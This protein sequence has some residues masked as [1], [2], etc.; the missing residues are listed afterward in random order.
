MSGESAA[1]QTAEAAEAPAK[2]DEPKE[3][4]QSTEKP[5]DEEKP[6]DPFD[7]ATKNLVG[8]N[9]ATRAAHHQGQRYLIKGAG[10]VLT[11]S[12]VDYL[13]LGNLTYV[14]LTNATK[15]KPG[16]VR[17]E[18]LEQIRASYVKV[19]TYDAI[20]DMLQSRRL[21]LLH[22]P[23]ETGRTTTALHLLDGVTGGRVDRLDPEAEVHSLT[24]DDLEAGRG[25]L[26]KLP[27]SSATALTETHLDRL[28]AS[29]VNKSCWC[30]LIVGSDF[31]SA[32]GVAGYVA[33]YGQL[34]IE[35]VF[36][37]HLARETREADVGIREELHR[38][39][40]SGKVREALG[41]VPSPAEMARL[42]PLLVKHDIDDVVTIL[43][44]YVDDSVAEWFHDVPEPPLGTADERALRFIGYRIALAVLNK[45]PQHHVA[46]AG[47]KLGRRLICTSDPL[48]EPGRPVF[49]SEHHLWL[50]TSRGQLVP[51]D[52]LFGDTTMRIHLAAFHDDRMPVAVLAQVWTRHHNTRA[53]LLQWLNELADSTEPDVWVRAAQAAGMLCTLDFPNV[54]YDLLDGWACADQ[55]HRRIVAA[56]ALEQAARYPDIRPAVRE[57][58]DRWKKLDDNDEARNWTAAATL[59]RNLGLTSAEETLDDLLTLSIEPDGQVRPII[60][61]VASESIARLLAHGE[62]D[63]VT[64][65]LIHWLKRPQ[66]SVRDVALL[67]IIKIAN[68]T[69]DDL[70]NIEF[71]TSGD[72]RNRWPRLA[73]RTGWPLLLALQEEDDQ[74]TDQFADL[75]WQI[76]NTA[77]SRGPAQ[78]VLTQWIRCG[79]SNRDCLDALSKFLTLLA[80]PPDSARRLQ[81][82]VADLRSQWQQPLAADVAEHL[83]QQL[84]TSRNG[85]DTP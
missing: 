84:A 16:P 48:R 33:E 30:V 65:R 2:D 24:T 21:V 39:A 67:A 51:D 52:V 60:G 7:T 22:G 8:S 43:E 18:E 63:R 70:E 37:C 44:R 76:L 12:R 77:R 34:D 71:F 69:V 62:V 9:A 78:N 40:D 73:S 38:L 49:A 4:V 74:L 68:T 14:N 27:T 80:Y 66:R 72:G 5:D 58:I 17:T 6:P 56:Y 28:S 32:P 25:Y 45:T 1:D 59:G 35:K 29:L 61:A 13:V 42:A 3:P 11:Q 83:R 19:A 57:V 15:P 64:K 26:R 31:S 23:A 36:R 53:P 46:E 10:A 41:P 55:P 20:L 50:S 54:F 75:I 79:N 81:R 82:L 85:V 47:E